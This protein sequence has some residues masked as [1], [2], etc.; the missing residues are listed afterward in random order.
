MPGIPREAE[1]GATLLPLSKDARDGAYDQ[2]LLARV[3][4]LAGQPDKAM[5]I[6]E[7]LLKVPF[8]VS[9]AWLRIDPE[10]TSLRGNP[11]FK[12]LSAG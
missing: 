4:L 6:L 1:R 9:P 12:R 10:W 2:Y 7:Q 3:Y 8:Y 11:R 5:D